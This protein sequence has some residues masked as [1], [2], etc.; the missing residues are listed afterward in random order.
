[1]KA[2]KFAV[3]LF[4]F[5][6]QPDLPLLD[7]QLTVTARLLDTTFVLAQQVSGYLELLLADGPSDLF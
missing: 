2:V 4:F 1:M 6:H 7:L 5:L 3:H